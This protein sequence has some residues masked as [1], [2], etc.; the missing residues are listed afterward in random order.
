[1]TPRER[2][3]SATW[4]L[5]RR[6]LPPP[7]AR[8]V[9]LGC[10]PLGGFVPRLRADGY[11]ATGIDPQAPDEPHYQR[12]PFESAALPRRL[13][14]VVASTSLHHVA[15]PADVLDRITTRLTSRGALL[16]IE[17]A[18]E[19]F[20]A[21]TAEWCFE[22]LALGEDEES[23]LHRRR[24]EWIE[25]RR[26]WQTYIRNWA[27]RE[28]LHSGDTLLRLVAKRFECRLLSHGPYF[29]P[30]LANTS[31]ADEQAAIDAGKIRATRL[32]YVGTL[33]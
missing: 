18:W 20:D 23:W 22:R 16:V 9:D 4:P 17:W 13:D 29:F 33:L 28:R 26:D 30:D 6:H 11:D 2:W 32:D 14:A 7:P 3:L 10:G 12:S 25:S 27:G 5:V 1:M 31:E 15:D 21:E 19:K 24:D 8:V